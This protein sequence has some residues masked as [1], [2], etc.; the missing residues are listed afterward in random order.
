MLNITEIDP[1]LYDSYLEQWL[2]KMARD[3]EKKKT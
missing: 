1:Q 3:F 2:A